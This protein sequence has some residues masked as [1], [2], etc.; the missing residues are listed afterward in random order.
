[1]L[2]LKKCLVYGVDFQ[3]FI[4]DVYQSGKWKKWLHNNSQDNKFLC[5]NIAGHYR[6]SQEP[7]QKIIE[8]LE[9]RE[10]IHETIINEIMEVIGHYDS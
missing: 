10:D 5:A 6:F 7:Y 8:E 1:M 3:K 4:E 9:Q 2:I